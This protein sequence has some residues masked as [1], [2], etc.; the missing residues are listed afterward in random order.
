MTEADWLASDDPARMLRL[1]ISDEMP[2]PQGAPAPIVSPRKLRL[3]ACACCRAVWDGAECGRCRGRGERPAAEP[4]SFGETDTCHACRGSGRV[5]GLTDPRSRAA[6]EVAERYA[7]VGEVVAKE[8]SRAWLYLDLEAP[9]EPAWM[10]A[11]LACCPPDTLARDLVNSV[12]SAPDMIPPATQAALLR[13]IVANP[14]RP[15]T[16]MKIHP[17]WFAVL[18]GGDDTI[19]ATAE[20]AYDDHCPADALGVLSDA[21]EEAGCDNEDMLRHLRGQE[22]C[23]TCCGLGVLRDRVSHV[24]PI[25]GPVPA[26]CPTCSP[27]GWVPLRGPHV[28]GCWAV[29][30]VLGKE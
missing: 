29:D 17:G 3:F 13:D 20:R 27:L 9:H 5:G 18:T 24:N 22:R 6:V 11:Y 30:L 7:D 1:Y 25:Y 26:A 21:L 19:R 28:R 12:F 4:R 10:F 23:P 16:D 14:W 2:W 15:N 8:M